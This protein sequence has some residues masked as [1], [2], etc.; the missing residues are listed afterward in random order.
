M[1][2]FKCMRVRERYVRESKPVNERE[3]VCVT[4]RVRV[5]E[6][7]SVCVTVRV[8]YCVCERESVCVCYGACVCM[9]VRES[10]CVCV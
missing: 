9:C 2:V 10:V 3:S 5:R 7:E 1:C 4:V 6:W 8:C